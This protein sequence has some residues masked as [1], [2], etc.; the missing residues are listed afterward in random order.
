[1]LEMHR[2]NILHLYGGGFVDATEDQIR[3]SI[4]NDVLKTLYF[5]AEKLHH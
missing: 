1:M 5:A 2:S 3:D 4:Y